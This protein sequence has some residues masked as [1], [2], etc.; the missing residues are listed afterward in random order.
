MST[1]MYNKIYEFLM[2]AKERQIN[3][4]SIIYLEMKENYWIF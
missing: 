1:V 3:A 4:T 2:T